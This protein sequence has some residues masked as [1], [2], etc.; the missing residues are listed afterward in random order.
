VDIDERLIA[1]L[2]EVVERRTGFSIDPHHLTL[3]GL[4][5]DCARVK[6]RRS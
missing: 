4:C 5:E 3:L 2:A 1:H 6:Q